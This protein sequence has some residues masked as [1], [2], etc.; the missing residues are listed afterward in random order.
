LGIFS[1]SA[2]GPDDPHVSNS[3]RTICALEAEELK[4]ESYGADLL[5]TIGFVYVAKAKHHLA[6]NQT[7]LGVGG[8]LHNVQGKYH[9]FSE[10]VSTLRSAIELKAVFDQIHAAEK[11]GNLSPEEKRKLEEQAAEKGLQALFKGAKLEIESV[12]RET[13]DRILEDPSIPSEKAHLRAVALQMLG[14]AYM[15]V[16][17]EDEERKDENDYVRVETKSSR[18]REQQRMQR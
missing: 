11:A 8:W 13:C 14:E 15:S 12:L 5:Q 16:R 7:F 18:S 3:W 2:T 9:V 10:T 1:E 4:K 17:K 6:T